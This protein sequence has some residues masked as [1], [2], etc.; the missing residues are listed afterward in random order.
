MFA[1]LPPACTSMNSILQFAQSIPLLDHCHRS[2][3]L[4]VTVHLIT[5]PG[6]SLP[7]VP[8]LQPVPGPSFAQNLRADARA[9]DCI[10]LVVTL[11]RSIQRRI[12]EPEGISDTT[13]SRKSKLSRTDLSTTRK[14]LTRHQ[15]VQGSILRAPDGCPSR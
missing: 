4:G 3:T 9:Q 1:L 13:S 11:R 7:F 10:R 2:L 12:E 8:R 15:G 14:L 5:I 6:Q